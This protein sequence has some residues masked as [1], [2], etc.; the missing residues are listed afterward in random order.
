MGEVSRNRATAE[1]L[2]LVLTL[3]AMAGTFAYLRDA[4]GRLHQAQAARAA[5]DLRGYTPPAGG[6]HDASSRRR[7]VA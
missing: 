1:A 4:H 2:K 7:L 6:H 3:A 5:A